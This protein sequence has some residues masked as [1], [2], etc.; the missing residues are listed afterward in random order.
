MAMRPPS[1]QGYSEETVE[2]LI[3]ADFDALPEERR[4]FALLT[5]PAACLAK[6]PPQ[7]RDV[8]GGSITNCS[9]RHPLPKASHHP[10]GRYGSGSPEIPG[11]NSLRPYA[12]SRRRLQRYW[13][14]S[15]FQRFPDALVEHLFAPSGI[16]A[17]E[18]STVAP[19]KR[20]TSLDG[21]F[22]SPV[23]LR[24]PRGSHRSRAT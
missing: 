8:P 4:H 11:P 17:P 3:E 2:I 20:V 6:L 12:L 23:A 1:P 13:L 16:D 9:V 19:P 5:F 14:K 7:R 10:A 18:I 15:S 21:W 22:R 24:K